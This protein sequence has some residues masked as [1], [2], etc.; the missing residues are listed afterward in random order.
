MRMRV[1]LWM[2]VA[3]SGASFCGQV[4]AFPGAEGYGA[5]TPGGRGG[6]VILV[7]NL[8]DAGPGSLRAACEAKGPRMVVFRVSGIIDLN[9]PVVIKEPRITI[10]GQSAPGDGVCLRRFGLAI[11]AQDVVVRY[12]RSRPG[13]V[14]GREVDAIAI[15]GTS[16]RVILDHCSASW[17]VDECLSPTGAI[18]DV[19]VQWSIISEGLNHSVHS[20]GAHGYGSL[21]RAVGGLSLHHNLWAH[22]SARNPRLGDNYGKPPYPLFDV[23][24][25]VMYDYGAV[26]SGMTGDI[27][28]VNYAGNYIQPGPSSNRRR[29]PIVLTPTAQAT[30]W[31]AGNVV[32]TRPELTADNAKLFDRTEADGRK[33][34]TLAPEPFEVPRVQTSSAEAA[35]AAVL[36]Q[37]G[38]SLPKRDAVDERVVSEVRSGTGRIIDSQWEVGG[39]PVYRSTRP[40]AD[41]D[42]D[43]MPDAWE[44]ARGLNPADPADAVADRD[45]DGYTNL[46][47]YLNGLVGPVGYASGLP[48]RPGA[49]AR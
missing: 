34:V 7:T 22:Q 2:S 20:K 31:V 21:V 1:W 9:S 39:W 44:K 8:N 18:A 16:R 32:V 23:R 47:E 36:A 11:D 49:V 42:R 14:A 46:E 30:Y 25:N 40:P 24:N 35:Y 45:R 28:S 6:K 10:A 48:R 17:S 27:L 26:C 12:L 5:M 13:D 43:G 19:T 33:L 38:A 4:P 3:A 41:T 29:G 15:G 37:A